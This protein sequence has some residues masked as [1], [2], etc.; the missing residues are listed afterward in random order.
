MTAVN[1]DVGATT[2]FSLFLWA[3]VYLVRRSFSLWGLIWAVAS[4]LLALWTKDTVIVA[5][6]L[7]L[8][9]VL[10][11]RNSRRRLA[12]VLLLAVSSVG[13]LT[14]FNWGDAAFWYRSTLQ[15]TPT[16]ASTS[17][18][19]LGSHAFRLDLLPTSQ[20]IPAIRQFIPLDQVAILRGK[21]VT[22][23]A[24][25]WADSPFQGQSP[26]LQF[27]VNRQGQVRHQDIAIETNP[28]FYAFVANI[29]DNAATIS[30]N[31]EQTGQGI[32]K[33]P[34]CFTMVW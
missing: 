14:I 10:L 15:S 28:K 8:L 1:N 29:P 17:Q 6:P 31:L 25:M 33:T 20:R 27:S 3:C 9:A 19:P 16:R 30:L 12:W 13:V 32:E 18:S 4:A 24:W 21:A 22:V 11:L 34:P 5:L 2:V 26:V 23:G 7:L